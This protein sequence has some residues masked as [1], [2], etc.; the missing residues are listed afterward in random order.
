MSPD[1]LLAN[2]KALLLDMNGTFMFGEDRFGP[3]ENYELQYRKLGGARYTS[4]INSIIRSAYDYLE[5]RYTDEVY[6]HRFPTV[7]TAIRETFGNVSAPE[8]ERMVATF[9]FHEMGYIPDAYISALHELH[10]HFTLAVVID[11]WA[12]SPFWVR[13]FQQA[14]IFD[15]FSVLYFS[16][17]HGI[18]KPSPEPFEMVLN[19]LDI[20]REEALMIGDSPRRDLGGARQAGLDCVLV[21]GAEHPEAVL[22]IDNL[23]VF[24][25]LLS[26]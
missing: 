11:I 6:R 9:A 18:V 13:A 4:A 21:G 22:S 14:E 23:L 7:E 17:D 26:S 20:Q 24:R 12:P 19:S 16:S 25:D 2:K 8:M 3:E 1:L 5:V 15:L 10:E